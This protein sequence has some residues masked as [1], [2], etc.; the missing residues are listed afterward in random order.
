MER[1]GTLKYSKIFVI[2]AYAALTAT[3]DEANTT[4]YR[5]SDPLTMPEA[6][7][8]TR[9]WWTKDLAL[10][11][12]PNRVGGNRGRAGIYMIFGCGSEGGTVARRRLQ[13]PQKIAGPV[14]VNFRST[15]S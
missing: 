11:P 12:N 9:A 6:A 15:A 10:Q 7:D 2:M 1:F 13:I 8:A 14:G 4:I 3:N 5:F